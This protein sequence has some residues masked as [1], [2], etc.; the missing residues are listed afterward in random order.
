MFPECLELGKEWPEL[1]PV[2]LCSWHGDT[3]RTA[4]VDLASE[5]KGGCCWSTMTLLGLSSLFQTH[6]SPD[7]GGKKGSSWCGVV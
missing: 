7:R 1:S 4:M 3:E 5:G 6:L 2:P